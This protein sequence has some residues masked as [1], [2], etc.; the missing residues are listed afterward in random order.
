MGWGL[1]QGFQECVGCLVGEHVGFVD[2]IDLVAG[3]CGGEVDLFPDIPDLVDAPVAGGVHLD[4]VEQAPLVG[5]GADVA[6]VAGVSIL[7]VQAVDRLGQDPG[8]G[9]LAG[10][11]GPAEQVGVGYPVLPD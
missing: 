2:D 1:L 7:G 5:G 10:A 11:P 6:P 3:L 8:G 9:G 4:D